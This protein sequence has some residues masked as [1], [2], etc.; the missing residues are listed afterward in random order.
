MRKQTIALA[1]ALWRFVCLVQ[2]FQ[3]SSPQK[4]KVASSASASAPATSSS[5]SSTSKSRVKP[6]PY[7]ATTSTVEHSRA[8]SQYI[9]Q[10][11]RVLELGT[12][13]DSCTETIRGAIGEEG[14]GVFVDVKRTETTSGRSGQ[15]SRDPN[16][17]QDSSGS[18]E[19]NA[20]Y[21]ELEQFSHFKTILDENIESPFDVLVLDITA[22][23]GNDLELTALSTIFEFVDDMT[24][25]GNKRPRAVIVKSKTIASLSRRLVHA[26]RLFD[27]TVQRDFKSPS[28]DGRP[29]IIAGVG[30]EEYRRTIPYVV[31]DSDECLE[32]G[33]KGGTSRY[34]LCCW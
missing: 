27:G 24:R 7:I 4:S 19:A 13:L 6:I 32:V 22:M 28:R 1:V 2:A 20:C 29:Y 15:G 9:R 21:V 30:V 31:R 11:D 25:R 10:G 14:H 16:M 8:L 5:S 26:Q 33:C 23:L 34:V 12:Q 17:F 18:N 3:I